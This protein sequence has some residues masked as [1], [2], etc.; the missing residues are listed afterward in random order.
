MSFKHLDSSNPLYSSNSSTSYSASSSPPAAA[1]VSSNNEISK[2]N[3][4]SPAVLAV[5]GVLGG[6]FLII[7]YYRIFSKYCNRSVLPWWGSRLAAAA[8]APH[9]SGTLVSAVYLRPILTCISVHGFGP[10]ASSWPRSDLVRS[11]ED[12][13]AT[14]AHSASWASNLFLLCL[15]LMNGSPGRGFVQVLMEDQM[16]SPNAMGLEEALIGRI[17][18][19]TFGAEQLGLMN[20][21]GCTN[22]GCSVCLSE[23]QEG[24]TLRILPKC[25]HSFHLLCIDT[26]LHSHSTCPL[27][28]VNIGLAAALPAASA[29][30]LLQP[31]TLEQQQQPDHVTSAAAAAAG[32][33]TSS[34]LSSDHV[35]DAAAAGP[36]LESVAAVQAA[37]GTH[38]LAGGTSSNCIN[39]EIQRLQEQLLQELL[40]DHQQILNS[41]CCISVTDTFSL[42]SDH[43]QSS[44]RSASSFVTGKSHSPMIGPSSV[45]LI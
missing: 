41:C 1:T 27:C 16:W 33:R 22:M 7:T 39:Q 20:T 40:Q 29:L 8:A 21:Q 36:W 12:S 42:N 44:F 35:E 43:L 4:F 34:E 19:C 14:S 9:P 38:A 28:R 17:P 24:D 11:W 32:P 30:T 3:A 13:G 6:A 15:I 5:I 25:N 23:Y 37:A 45:D 2:L 18:T 31:M 26:W 10:L